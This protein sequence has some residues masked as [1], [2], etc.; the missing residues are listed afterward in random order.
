MSA[1]TAPPGAPCLQAVAPI[2]PVGDVRAAIEYYG[3]VLGF[4]VG[5]SWGEPPTVASVCRD[6]VGLMLECRDDTVPVGT[7]RVYVTMRGVQAFHDAAVASGARAAVPLGVR[8]HG[9]RDCRLIDPD[10]NAL[11]FGEPV[12]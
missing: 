12:G 7:A 6:G 3:T 8:E 10:G 1:G 2:L 9:M 11:L 5:W 4:R